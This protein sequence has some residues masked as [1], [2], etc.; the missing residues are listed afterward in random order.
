MDYKSRCN[1]RL[2]CYVEL[3]RVFVVLLGSYTIQTSQISSKILRCTSYF[4]LSSQCLSIH[5]TDETLSL[6][7]DIFPKDWLKNSAL[8]LFDFPIVLIIPKLLLSLWLPFSLQFSEYVVG[9]SEVLH[10]LVG[11]MEPRQV[12]VLTRSKKLRDTRVQFQY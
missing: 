9:S 4:Q 6:V 10:M 1:I 2:N 8:N 12:I 11:N 3:C 5:C 7:F